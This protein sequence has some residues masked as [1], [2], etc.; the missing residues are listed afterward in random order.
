MSKPLKKTCVPRPPANVQKEKHR[1]DVSPSLFPPLAVQAIKPPQHNG[2]LLNRP[3]EPQP[4]L[5]YISHGSVSQEQKPGTSKQNGLKG[6]SGK[7]QKHPKKKEP[8]D[9]TE[10]LKKY[11][12]RLTEFEQKEILGYTEIW[13]LGLKAMKIRKYDDEKGHYIMVAHDHIAYRYEVLEEMGLGAF[14]QVFKCRDHKTNEM[15]AIK[16]LC[17]MKDDQTSKTEV[18]ILEALLKKDKDSSTKTVQMKEHFIFRRHLC[19][20]FELLGS[21]LNE[22]LKKRHRQ[23]LSKN[24]VRRYACSLLKCLQALHDEK[25]IHADLKPENILAIDEEHSDIKVADFGCGCYEDEKVFGYIGTRWYRAPELLLRQPYGTAIDMWS[26][27][28]VL[29]ELHTG[30]PIFTGRNELDQLSCIMQ[31]LGM[32]SIDVT[33]KS[34]FWTAFF[35]RKW[36][37]KTVAK[38]AGIRHPKSRPLVN[39]LGT[40]DPSFL[41]FM[42]SCLT[43]DPKMRM[44]PQEAMQHKWILEGHR[45]NHNGTHDHLR[46]EPKDSTVEPSFPKALLCEERLARLRNAYNP[47]KISTIKPL[48]KHPP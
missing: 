40:T 6:V 20:A 21:N 38:H 33:E 2:R 1:P 48:V 8:L 45:N 28:C 43:W 7:M 31:V 12:T 16:I 15:V 30:Q 5:P 22:I 42:Q 4:K 46:H 44:T 47:L 13:Y 24:L 3:S 27:G 39:I 32:P 26:L 10:A 17:I 35:A 18:K 29:A 14:G 41:D 34:E 11:G 19:I 23:G 37:N 36:K 9:V 25:I